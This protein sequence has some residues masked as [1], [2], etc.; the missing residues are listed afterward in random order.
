MRNTSNRN[1]LRTDMT[2]HGN[3]DSLP[4]HGRLISATQ[5]D[6]TELPCV[7]ESA[8]LQAFEVVGATD[9]LEVA[10]KEIFLADEKV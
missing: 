5:D 9:V 10:A 1:S 7:P 4:R 8:V 6:R 3:M 2:L